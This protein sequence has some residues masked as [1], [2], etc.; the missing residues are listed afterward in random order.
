MG[1]W[2]TSRYGTFRD[3]GYGYQWWSSRVG[4]HH[5]GYAAGHGGNYIIL[6][7]ELDMIIVTTADPL[8]GP[9]LAA[10]GGWEYEGAINELVGK[11]IKSLPNQ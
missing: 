6:L 5:F 4:K 3:L 7:D 8:K 9:E 11:F 1:E 10:G 2:I